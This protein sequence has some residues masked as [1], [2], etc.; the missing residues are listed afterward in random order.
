LLCNLVVAAA[1][2]NQDGDWFSPP[3]RKPGA[4][5][6]TPAVAQPPELLREPTPQFTAFDAKLAQMREKNY[7]N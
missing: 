4:K 3:P 2:Q 5:Y 7:R 6:H 1:P